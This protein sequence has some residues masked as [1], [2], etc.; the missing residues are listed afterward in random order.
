MVSSGMVSSWY[1]HFILRYGVLMVSSG[2]VS[3]WEQGDCSTS[4]SYSGDLSVL[5]AELGRA[6]RQSRLKI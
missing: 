2:M 3:S 6:A 1:P 4:Q 5:Q